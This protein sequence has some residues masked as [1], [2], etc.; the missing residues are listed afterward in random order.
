MTRARLARRQRLRSKSG[1][2]TTVT[3]VAGEQGREPVT[4][5]D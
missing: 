2:I 1:P 3:R 5:T 4:A